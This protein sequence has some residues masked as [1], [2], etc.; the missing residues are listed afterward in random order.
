MN[1][2]RL[3]AGV[4][5]ERLAVEDL[6]GAADVLRPLYDQSGGAD[7]FISWEVSPELADDTDA[8]LAEV[9]R[10]WRMFDRPNAMI[11]IPGTLAGLP[12]IEAALAE[13][14]NINITLLFAVQRYEQVVERRLALWSVALQAGN[15][16][17]AC[18]RSPASSSIRVDTLVDRL[19]EENGGR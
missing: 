11:K 18:G 8:T 14:I 6:R 15:R 17:T 10:L 7:G 13:G 5:F 2:E 3:P 16:W 4:V 12:A 19:L 1:G 9:R